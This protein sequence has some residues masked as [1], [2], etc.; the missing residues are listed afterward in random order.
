MFK[1]RINKKGQSLLEYVLL[2]IIVMGAFLAMQNYIKRGVQGRWREAVDDMGSQY[3]PRVASGEVLHRV[4]SNSETI[5]SV[6]KTTLSDGTIQ[7]HTARNDNDFSV[8]TKK[9]S[10]TVGGY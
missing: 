9:G 10:L 8:E 7:R 3:D 2:I 6:E 5:V 1:I 4:I